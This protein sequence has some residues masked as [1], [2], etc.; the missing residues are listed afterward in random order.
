M[1]PLVGLETR[2]S[3]ERFIAI[4]PITSVQLIGRM[5]SF[6]RLQMMAGRKRSAATFFYA[7]E[8]HD[9]HV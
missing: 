2:L 5:R 8:N 1:T 3:R 4:Q 6:M 9:N 7:S